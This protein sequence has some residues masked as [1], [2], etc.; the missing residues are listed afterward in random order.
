[1]IPEIDRVSTLMNGVV[2]LLCSLY[3]P[4]CLSSW[5]MKFG[6]FCDRTTVRFVRLCFC[7]IHTQ[8]CCFG[9]RPVQCKYSSVGCDWV[10]EFWSVDEH[11]T[12]CPSQMMMGRDLIDS[13]RRMDEMKDR[14]MQ[15]YKRLLELLSCEKV[16]L[17]GM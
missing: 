16:E 11:E 13:V 14:E 15:M 17:I 10:G 8:S 3:L 1:M 6:G 12:F 7:L 9:C 4:L 2:C 5:C